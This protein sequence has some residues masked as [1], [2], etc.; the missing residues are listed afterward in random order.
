MALENL[1]PPK[2]THYL[3]GRK[4]LILFETFS[5]L[6]CEKHNQKHS[7]NMYNIRGVYIFV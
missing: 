5:S 6:K 4:V 3:R 7:E 1:T 2:K